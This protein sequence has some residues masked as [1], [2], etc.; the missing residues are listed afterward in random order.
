MPRI[1]DLRFRRLA[2]AGAK[3]RRGSPKI[4]GLREPQNREPQNRG[5][6]TGRPKQ[7]DPKS[8]VLYRRI[9]GLVFKGKTYF[10]HKT[11]LVTNEGAPKL[12]RETQ[13]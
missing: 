8:G 5:S 4:G 10:F 6:S 3:V 12:E 2:Y 9:G 7:G 1:P 13:N 11:R